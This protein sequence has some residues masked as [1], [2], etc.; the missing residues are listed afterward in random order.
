MTNKASVLIRPPSSVLRPPMR[1]EIISIG[2][3]LLLG[4]IVDTNA[5][6]LAQQLAAT[7]VDVYFRTTVGDN[8]G[9]IAE[10]IRNA[11]ARAD[12][13]IT[14]GGLGP[15]VDDMTREGIAQAVGVPL[16]LKEEL[17]EQIRARFDKWGRAM[18]ENNVR[19]AYVPRGATTVENP[20]GT[21]PCFIVEHEG[22]FIFVLPGV[23]REMKYLTETRLLP[24]LREKVGN[25]GIILSKTL[26]T[27]AVG[28]S[29][30][31]EKIGDL[32]T[33]RNPTVGLAAHAGQTDIR[34]TA[35]GQT[36]AEAEQMIQEMEARVR[37]R[38][39]DWIYGEGD[40]SVEQ[41]IARLVVA[42]EK[43]IALL[44]SNTRGLLA[45][46]LRAT[47]EQLPIVAEQVDVNDPTQVNESNAAAFARELFKQS[48]AD[49][50]LA[51]LG[52]MGADED[53]YSTNTGK[54]AIALAFDERVKTYEFPIGGV[55]EMAQ[56]WTAMRALDILRRA[57]L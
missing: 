57:L 39:G 1:A 19:Q 27:I 23:P 21:A 7:G 16:V 42:K 15:T 5:A 34:I 45:E 24:W 18:S 32:E 2:T 4:E 20:V 22:H 35:K 17:I 50:A 56:Q 52:T 55:T 46:R 25:E 41:V 43:K 13:V 6:W 36:R 3:E 47:P 29:L 14:T 30:I 28:E 33:E 8:V 9:R 40:E 44:E 10:V 11:L 12:V 49:Y 37:E 38:L 53:M 51:V 54:T 26:R 48:G 31:D